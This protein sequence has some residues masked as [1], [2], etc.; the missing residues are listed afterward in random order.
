M[1]SALPHTRDETQSQ[2][3]RVEK[4]GH[5]GLWQAGG[6]AAGLYALH[7]KNKH[8]VQNGGKKPGILKGAAQKAL[9]CAGGAVAGTVGYKFT[10]KGNKQ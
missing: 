6:C 8:K 1:A 10:H 9:Y 2:S 5:P 4:K 3:T 7:R